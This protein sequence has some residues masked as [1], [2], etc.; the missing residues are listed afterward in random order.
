MAGRGRIWSSAST[1]C[2][3]RKTYDQYLGNAAVQAVGHKRW[4]RRVLKAI[5]CIATLTNFDTLYIGGGNAR[6]IVGELPQN[7][8]IVP[9]EAGITG[10]IRLWDAKLDAM[11]TTD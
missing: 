8:R 7:V 4:N 5:G 1:R 9:N 11:F 3:A 10:G 2:A 6:H